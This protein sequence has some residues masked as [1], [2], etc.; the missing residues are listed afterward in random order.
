MHNAARIVCGYRTSARNR[1]GLNWLALDRALN[2]PAATLLWRWQLPL[3]CF[4]VDRLAFNRARFN[5]LA[6]FAG[7]ELRIIRVHIFCHAN[8]TALKNGEPGGSGS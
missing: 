4:D 2:N 1:A 8:G 3:T 6:I 5:Q 7:R